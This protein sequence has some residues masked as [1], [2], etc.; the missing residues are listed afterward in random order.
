MTGLTNLLDTSFIREQ[1]AKAEAERAGQVLWFSSLLESL[2]SGDIESVRYAIE[3]AIH[4][5]NK[6]DQIEWTGGLWKN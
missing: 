6:G 4:L 1:A 3:A 2:H 5:L